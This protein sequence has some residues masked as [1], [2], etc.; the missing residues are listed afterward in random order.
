MTAPSTPPPGRR[1]EP[2]RRLPHHRRGPRRQPRR[3]R[4]YW[5]AA[6]APLTPSCDQII[7]ET[8]GDHVGPNDPRLPAGINALL[9]DY[10]A[11]DED[12]APVF[13]P[14]LD[15][16]RQAIRDEQQKGD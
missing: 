15:R 1:H 14:G 12:L 16:L 7:R 11:L 4:R 2:A 10:A 13:T 6:P 5:S 8:L 3:H 9:D